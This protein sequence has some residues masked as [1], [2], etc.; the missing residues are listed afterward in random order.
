MAY[1]EDFPCC[2]HEA[3][4]CPDFDESGRQLNMR[5][6]CGAEVP[7]SSPSS[8]CSTCLSQGDPDDPDPW[9]DE[10][11][12]DEADPYDDPDADWMDREYEDQFE[13]Y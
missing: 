8:L 9:Y 11:E 10:E 5:C 12:A 3:G 7:L 2:G 4:C 6:V 1:C 13:V